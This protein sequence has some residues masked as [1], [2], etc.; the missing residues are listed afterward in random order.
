MQDISA[1][2]AYRIETFNV[3]WGMGIWVRLHDE[4]LSLQEEWWAYES[5]SNPGKGVQV[6][7]TPPASGTYYLEVSTSPRYAGYCDGAYDLMILPEGTQI[8]LPLVV[9]NN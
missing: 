2:T 1:G 7:W 6:H 4:S 8:Y 5:S 9:R 3:G